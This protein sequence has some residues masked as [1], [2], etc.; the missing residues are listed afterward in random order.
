M[1]A[2]PAKYVSPTAIAGDA[3]VCPQLANVEAI[4]R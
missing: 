4:W 3:E 2:Q 1:A